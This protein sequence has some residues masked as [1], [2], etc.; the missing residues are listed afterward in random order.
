MPSVSDC[1]T[2]SIP[3]YILYPHWYR[4]LVFE[5]FANYFCEVNF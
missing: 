1:E 3:I 2:L 4:K 5:C